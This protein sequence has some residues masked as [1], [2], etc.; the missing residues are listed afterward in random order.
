MSQS[1]RLVPG[2]AEVSTWTPT[3]PVHVTHPRREHAVD[4]RQRSWRD[5]KPSVSSADG[6]YV[7]G[8]GASFSRR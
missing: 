5:Q 7:A 1:P 6:P 3:M 2:V 8:N 4:T